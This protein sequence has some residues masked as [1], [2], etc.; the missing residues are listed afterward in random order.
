MVRDGTEAPHETDVMV[1]IRCSI[2]EYPMKVWVSLEDTIYDLKEFMGKRMELFQ[3]EMTF[4]ICLSYPYPLP[5]TM[6][7]CQL[8]DEH[9]HL[10]LRIHEGNEECYGRAEGTSVSWCDGQVIPDRYLFT[11]Q[12]EDKTIFDFRYLAPSQIPRIRSWIYSQRNVSEIW[13]LGTHPHVSDILYALAE[14]MLSLVALDRIVIHHPLDS[15]YS[16]PTHSEGR[17]LIFHVDGIVSYLTR[18]AVVYLYQHL[19]LDH[20]RN[21]VEDVS[22]MIHGG[23]LDSHPET[24]RF[25]LN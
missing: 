13:L 9:R 11:N 10:I 15:S 3:D 23:L 8:L 20:Y 4:I 5:D 22:I 16:I 7:L 12:E 18:E 21:S 6:R 25:R 2:Y 1:T 19:L 14:D 17:H 24:F